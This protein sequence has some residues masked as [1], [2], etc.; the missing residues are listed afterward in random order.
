MRR[1]FWDTPNTGA[2]FFRVTGVS[3]PR[4]PNFPGRWPRKQAPGTRA[5]A[6]PSVHSNGCCSLTCIPKQFSPCGSTYS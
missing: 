1:A 2:P 6:N 4:S 3:V 5:P